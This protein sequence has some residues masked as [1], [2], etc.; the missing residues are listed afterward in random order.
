[1]GYSAVW[2][3]VL[4]DN[5][6]ALAAYRAAGF[7]TASPAQEREFNAGQPRPYRWLLGPAEGEPGTEPGS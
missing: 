4:P 7:L 3:R 2:L 1:M 5:A 6:A